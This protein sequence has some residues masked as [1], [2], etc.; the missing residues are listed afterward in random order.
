M[1]S[2]SN[3]LRL[4]QQKNANTMVSTQSI[5]KMRFNCKLTTGMITNRPQTHYCDVKSTVAVAVIAV[6][7]PSSMQVIDIK[8]QVKS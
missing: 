2:N 6:K 4:I 3:A 7:K 5:L 1:E 8:F